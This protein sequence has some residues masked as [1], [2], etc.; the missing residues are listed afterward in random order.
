[1][2]QQA[3]EWG[4]SIWI[5]NKFPGNVYATVKWP[6]FARQGWGWGSLI[7][8]YHPVM[9]RGLQDPSYWSSEFYYLI[10]GIVFQIYCTEAGHDH[11][12]LSHH[13]NIC[14]WSHRKVLI[15][16][17]QHKDEL[18]IFLFHRKTNV[19]NLLTASVMTRSWIYSFI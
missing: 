11:E 3:W 1:M 4:L 15:K 18:L 6:H 19:L 10:N 12:N 16:A 2:I 9:Y 14:S 7:H 17:L 5:C 13:T 8:S